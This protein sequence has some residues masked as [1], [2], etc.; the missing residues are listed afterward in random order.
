MTHLQDTLTNNDRVVCW[1]ES[2]DYM[3]HPDFQEQA[4]LISDV[5]GTAKYGNAAY[6]IPANIIS[7]TKRLH[8]QQKDTKEIIVSLN[9]VTDKTLDS[10]TSAIRRGLYYGLDT[11][12]IADPTKVT[13]NYC[14]ER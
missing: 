1:P 13:I 10:I 9:I 3:E 5:E 12:R 6:I 8:A 7:D 11:K 4:I 2:Q 14:Q